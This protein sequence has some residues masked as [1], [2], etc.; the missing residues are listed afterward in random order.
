VLSYGY[1]Q[2]VETDAIR[3]YARLPVFQEYDCLRE[4]L[5]ALRI[6]DVSG[7]DDRPGLGKSCEGQQREDGRSE[8]ASDW[9]HLSINALAAL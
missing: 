2:G 9:N 8:D 5:A 1:V 6:A 3:G 7:Q 4:R